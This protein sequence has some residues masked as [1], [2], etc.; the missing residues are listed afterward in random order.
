VGGATGATHRFTAAAADSLKQYRAVFTNSVSSATSEAALLTVRTATGQFIRSM[1]LPEGGRIR[2]FAIDPGQPQLIYAATWSAGVYRSVDEG[3]SWLPVLTHKGKFDVEALA[4]DPQSPNIVYAGTTAGLYKSTDRGSTWSIYGTGLN[5][6]SVAVD[7]QSSLVLYAGTN[8][9][10]AR[11]STDGGVSWT[12]VLD[13]QIDA[14]VSAVAVD[15][16]D[17]NRLFFGSDVGMWASADSGSSW[18]KWTMVARSFAFDPR[19]PGV[20]YVTGDGVYRSTDNGENFTRMS[21]DVGDGMYDL[22]MAIDPSVSTTIYV[23]SYTG[24]WKSTDSGAT[25]TAFGL[26][27]RWGIKGLAVGPAESGVIYAGTNG[28]GLQKSR[29]GGATWAA[30]NTGMSS[31]GVH[32]LS[33]DPRNPRTVLAVSGTSA[34]CG[35]ELFGSGGNGVWRSSDGGTTWSRMTSGLTAYTI[36]AIVRDPANPDVVYVGGGSDYQAA[37]FRSSD[38]GSTWT[39][40]STGLPTHGVMTLMADSRTT[41]VLYAGTYGDGVFKTTDSGGHWTAVNNGLT[42]PSVFGLGADP[43]AAD[44]FYAGTGGDGVF[45]TSDGGAHWTMTGTGARTVLGFAFDPAHA[46][47]LFAAGWVD[48]IYTT[49]DGGATWVAASGGPTSVTALGIDPANA[50]TFYAA[51]YDDGLFT[52]TDAGVTWTV[53][54]ASVQ[55]VTATAIAIPPSTSGWLYVGSENAG[56]FA[57]GTTS[58]NWHPADTS[59][60]GRLSISEITAYGAAWKKGTVWWTGPNPIP[61]GYVTRAGYLWRNGETYQRGAGEC[62]A[63]WAT[64]AADALDKA[65]SVWK[66]SFDG[67]TQPVT[68][69]PEVVAGRR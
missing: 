13:G 45:K 6:L 41:G 1:Q 31:G 59:G 63:C 51:S 42:S 44:T 28:A 15:P 66:V 64:S 38:G 17:S 54:D 55:P 61:I 9:T 25:W 20:M 8:G 12:A 39:S 68:G 58:T 24:L 52:S 23:G 49:A 30:S 36:T 29:D 5:F 35:I 19:N 60:D 53:V 21:I 67:G 26:A 46:G 40:V 50:Q 11:K 27:E 7:P 48:G 56:V 69:V 2:A 65:A 34:F 62:P 47:V 16:R 14:F 3:V 57:A 10:G 22:S 32:G 37:V 33:V 18:T 4:I 43:L